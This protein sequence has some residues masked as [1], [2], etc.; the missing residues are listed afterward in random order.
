MLLTPTHESAQEHQY[1]QTQ[2]H[3][4]HHTHRHREMSFP[5]VLIT[6]S[7]QIACNCFTVH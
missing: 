2:A 7:L 1:P 5:S 4:L 3:T 6:H